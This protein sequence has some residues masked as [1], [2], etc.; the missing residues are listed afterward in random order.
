MGQD[1]PK[2]GQDGPKMAPRCAQDWANMG[3]DVPKMGPRWA[4]KTPRWAQDGPQDGPKMGPKSASERVL[5]KENLISRKNT[6]KNTI[7]TRLKKT[8]KIL[9][10]E[11]PD[12]VPPR[13]PPALLYPEAVHKRPVHRALPA[14]HKRP[15]LR[16]VPVIHRPAGSSVRDPERILTKQRVKVGTRALYD[17][18]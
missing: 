17:P 18:P 1:G 15:A 14:I 5:G 7:V 10:T 13:T 8:T 3:Q 6:P 2:M 12:C 11:R 4:K 16:A 9:I